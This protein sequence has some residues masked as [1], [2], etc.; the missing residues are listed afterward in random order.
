MIKLFLTKKGNKVMLTIEL[1]FCYFIQYSL[2]ISIE[3]EKQG[4]LV[5]VWFAISVTVS[6]LHRTFV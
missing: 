3:V 5:K 2:S 6:N 4:L 1:N